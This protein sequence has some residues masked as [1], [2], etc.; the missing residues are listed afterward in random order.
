MLKLKQ[1]FAPTQRM[2]PSHLRQFFN[3]PTT[4]YW[5][6]SAQICNHLGDFHC[7]MYPCACIYKEWYRYHDSDPYLHFDQFF[8]NPIQ[9]T[10]T[11]PTSIA[12]ICDAH[13]SLCTGQLHSWTLLNVARQKTIFWTD[14]A[15]N[16]TKCYHFAEQ[17]WWFETMFLRSVI[18]GSQ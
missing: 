12:D 7:R 15:L 2:N 8:A 13:L 4:L 18:L 6:H 17:S 11:G 1:N 9:I 3:K 14:S 5:A 16:A 10:S